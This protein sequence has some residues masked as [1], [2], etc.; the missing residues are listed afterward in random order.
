VRSPVPAPALLLVAAA[1]VSD[2]VPGLYD[3]FTIHA[4]EW[5]AVVALI[6]IL[7]NGG[8]DLGWARARASRSGSPGRSRASSAR[9]SRRPT[10][11]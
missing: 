4:V 2:L 5:V 6:V 7:F 1:V 10:R 11:R 9:R 8:M 3:V